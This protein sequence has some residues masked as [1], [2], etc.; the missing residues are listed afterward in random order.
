[1]DANESPAKM[2]IES[3]DNKHFKEFKKLTSVDGVRKY[4][5]VI[6]SGKKLIKEIIQSAAH[7]C[8]ALIIYERYAEDDVETNTIIKSFSDAGLLYTLKKHLYNELDTFNTGAPLLVI[9]VPE[10]PEWDLNLT[11]GCNLLIPFQDPLN[12][13]AVIRSAAGFGVNKIIMLKEAAHPFHPRSI[14]AS[15]GAV[16]KYLNLP[17]LGGRRLREGGTS[18][19]G[20]FSGPSITDLKKICEKIFLIIIALDMSGAPISTYY[21]PERFLLLPGIEG[22]GVPEKLKVNAISIP[23]SKSIE[24]LNAAVATSISLFYW[25]FGRG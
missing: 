19:T 3:K 12:V 4:G 22:Q 2:I 14:R 16:L 18:Q 13:G 1:L 17:P 7:S 21:F 10:I 6:V 11:E 9:Q 23:I 24:S 15:A 5:R 25:K 8:V 20:L